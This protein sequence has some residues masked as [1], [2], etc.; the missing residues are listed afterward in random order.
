MV[1]VCGACDSLTHC[2]C[3]TGPGQPHA[4]RVLRTRPTGQP[5]QFGQRLDGG[6]GCCDLRPIPECTGWLPYRGYFLISYVICAL[7]AGVLA[8]ASKC[9]RFH[10][11]SNV[12]SHSDWSEGEYVINY[13]PRA[14]NR[15]LCH[16]LSTGQHGAA[17]PGAGLR[18]AVVDLED[19]HRKGAVC[20]YDDGG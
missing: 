10:G 4:R 1:Y 2:L 8:H 15:W 13:T 17:H 12:Y 16:L 5:R 11:C 9:Y 20:Q 14:E 19:V 3:C 18:G 7:V 6:G